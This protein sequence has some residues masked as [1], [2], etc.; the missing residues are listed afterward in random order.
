MSRIKHIL[1]TII[2]LC[3]IVHGAQAAGKNRVLII[4]SYG[5]DYQWSNTVT[6]SV[7]LKIRHDFPDTE[8]CIEYLA[9]ERDTTPLAW[10]EHM[11]MLLSNYHDK[12]PV[13]IV[14]IS[15]EAW[16]AYRAVNTDK[17]KDIPI[18]LCGIKS[19]SIALDQYV[20]R[21]DSLTVRDFQPTTDILKQYNATGVLRDLDNGKHI[22][23]IKQVIPNLD[24]FA[25]I[26]DNT[27][28]GIYTN[29][30]CR[31]YIERMYP[32][33]K[34][35]YIDTRFTG[36][37][38]LLKK[39]SQTTPSTGILIT[40][41][42]MGDKGFPYSRRYV[43]EQMFA[44]SKAPIFISTNIGMSRGYFLGGY[45]YEPQFWGDKITSVLVRVLKGNTIDNIPVEIYDNAPCYI[46]WNV[47]A[48]FNLN[49][50]SFPKDTIFINKPKSVVE[51]YYMYFILGGIILL[52]AVV[53]L[54][55][56]TRNNLKLKHAQKL[57][58]AAIYQSQ[59]ANIN[60]TQTQMQLQQALHE[61]EKADRL[62]SAFISNMDSEIRTPL[63]AIVGFANIIGTMDQDEDRQQAAKQI[64]ENSEHLLR[65][66]KNILDLAHMENG[67]MEL[68]YTMA[69]LHG[70]CS[71][72]Y[73]LCHTKCKQG[74]QMKLLMPE[75][76]ISI[77]TDPGRLSQALSNL[78]DNAIKF[79]D[80]GQIELGYFQ[81]DAHQVEL[82]VK[83]T[84]RGIENDKF[85]MIFERFSKL[86]T[87]TSG[88]GLGLAI[89][90]QLAQILGG[91][92]GVRSTPGQGSY[93][94]IRVQGDKQ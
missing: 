4:S 7:N 31:D 48:K 1:T 43:Y 88:S 80:Q 37:D 57:I 89:S 56:V 91:Q 35:I 83:D 55:Y 47:L 28:Y 65:L 24:S 60:L 3:F 94:W 27:F 16:M 93:F 72:L 64:C 79:T 62:K 14:L 78:L 61:A 86:E 2:C 42:L 45:M 46:N 40:S 69:N 5:S 74:V 67:D 23:L 13:A 36:T 53:G 11:S 68:N 41:W 75:T 59:Q 50:D 26:T 70:T 63:S 33:K 54:I 71:D 92:I 66:I 82:Y 87:Y 90:K 34:T 38:T 22:E 15:D 39:I 32:D 30:M 81:Y 77:C 44:T 20:A 49:P 10:G 9:C 19:Q 12:K 58:Q 17:F 21:Y 29:V 25:I 85:E 52:L 76:P 8:I 51:L 18:L 73:S 84:G 6:D